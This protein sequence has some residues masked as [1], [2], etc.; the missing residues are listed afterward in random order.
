MNLE[1]VVDQLI[2]TKQYEDVELGSIELLNDK[3]SCTLLQT[4]R[5]RVW[6]VPFKHG[7]SERGAVEGAVIHAIKIGIIS[8]VDIPVQTK[9]EKKKLKKK[10]KEDL[11]EE[12]NI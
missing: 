8:G 6:K 1:E 10:P 4:V 3:Y 2:K 5:D 12:E 7:T 11:I 9:E